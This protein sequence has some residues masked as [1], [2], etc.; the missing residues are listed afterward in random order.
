M[1]A[2]V[3]S[4]PRGISWPARSAIAIAVAAALVAIADFLFWDSDLGGLSLFLFNLAIAAGILIVRGTKPLTR[5]VALG[6]GLAV[7]GALPLLEAPSL[8][9]WLSAT[10]GAGMLA[11]AAVSELPRNPVDLPAVLL[12]F[13]IVAPGRFIADAV[14]ATWAIAERG[15][16]KTLLR[17]VT[18]WL[19]PL[20]LA[21]VFLWLFSAA[22]PLIENALLAINL[23]AI[24]QLLDPWRVIVW[25]V[26][27]CFVWPLLVPKLLPVWN[28]PL[29]HGPHRPARESTVFGTGAILRALVLFNL[30]F[31]LQTGLDIAYLWGGVK[32]PEGLTYASY[33]HRGA[34][35]LIA[36]ALLAAVFVL[37]AMRPGGPAEN[38]VPI[39]RLVYVFIAQNVLLVVSSILRLDLYVESYMLT[40]LRVAAGV[41][42]GLVA[43]GLVLILIRIALGK[44]NKWLV[45][46]NLLA[47][48]L[49]LYASSF[50]DA[51][52]LI[53][54]FNVDH[55]R[56]LTGEGTTLDTQY[57]WRG[58]GPAAIPALD[59]FIAEGRAKPIAPAVLR[60]A[61]NIRGLLATEFRQ[62]VRGWRQWTFRNWRLE[63]YLAGP[64]A[65]AE[66]AAPDRTGGTAVPE[67]A[68]PDPSMP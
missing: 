56:E 6:A 1:N 22:N 37:A 4:P 25:G 36:T 11:L 30:L 19:V 26:I 60:D 5:S 57:L 33:A 67:P 42:M 64:G 28:P 2:I 53:S 44:S 10:F 23:D 35:P 13:G 34:Y 59:R 55:S 52:A 58:I 18:M 20:A 31:A 8:W 21:A 3:A 48:G 62:R 40:E 43:I 66:P 63:Q 45:A 29:V 49:T 16:G 46:T 24:L 9:G 41:W 61:E 14:H 65:F 39:R 47:L 12:R 32:L 50:I 27:L 68:R 15:L 17:T 38:S 51:G 7:L 54:R